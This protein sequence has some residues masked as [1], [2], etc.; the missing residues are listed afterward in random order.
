MTLLPTSSIDDI[1]CKKNLL[2][3]VARDFDTRILIMWNGLAFIFF[4]N[5]LT[6]LWLSFVK[7]SEI[8]L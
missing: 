7:F 3:I 2:L 5:N 1:T 6:G 8:R 4:G